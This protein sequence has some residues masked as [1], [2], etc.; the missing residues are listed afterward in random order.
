MDVEGISLSKVSQRKT[1]TVQ[2]HLHVESKKYN[3]S[4]NETKKKQFSREPTSVYQ[5]GEGSGERQ[6][7]GRGKK[8]IL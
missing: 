7:K 2:Y 6:Q 8:G 5:L 1:N 4:M 3:K